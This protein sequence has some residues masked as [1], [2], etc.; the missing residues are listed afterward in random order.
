LGKR[1]KPAEQVANDACDEFFEF[2]QTNATIDKYLADQL[3]LYMA[4]ARGRSTLITSHITSHL[5][6]NAWLI[7]QF[8]PVKFDIDSSIGKVSVESFTK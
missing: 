5:H 2:M 1:G 4:L 3:L 7:E 6:T 8:L